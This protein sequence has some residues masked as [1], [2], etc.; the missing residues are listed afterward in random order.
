M[1]G[2]NKLETLRSFTKTLMDV[3]VEEVSFASRR[4]MVNVVDADNG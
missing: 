3:Q 2:K 4:R 1:L